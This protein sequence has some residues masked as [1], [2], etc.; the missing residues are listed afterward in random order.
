MR[1]IDGLVLLLVTVKS[2][3]DKILFGALI[4]QFASTVPEA[5]ASTCE[6][7]SSEEPGKCAQSKCD[8]VIGGSQY[9]SQ[10]SKAGEAPV[11]GVCT[12]EL[13]GNNC[14]TKI[15]TQ[16]AQGYFLHKGGCYKIGG[17]VGSLICADTS[18]PGVR[19]TAGVCEDCKSGYFKN[20]EAAAN[21]DSCISCGDQAGFTITGG[22]GNTYKG[23]QNCATC[24]PPERA[25]PGSSQQKEAMCESCV[26]GFFGSNNC[27]QQ[28]TDP[29]AACKTT[30]T[31]CTKCKPGPSNTKEYFKVTNLVEKTG[32]C[33]AQDACTDTYFPTTDKAGTKVCVTC[34][35]ETNGG[36][37]DCKTCISKDSVGIVKELTLTCSTCKTD[38]NKPNVVGSQCFVCPNNDSTKDCGKCSAD[39]LCEE[40]SGGKVLTPTKLCLEDCSGLPGYF[41]DTEAKQ[42]VSC[43]KDCKECTGKATQ[44]TACSP[45]RMLV[46]DK[47]GAYPYGT[48]VDQCVVAEGTVPGT[49]GTCGAKIGGTAYCSKCNVAA[50][51]PVNGVC[52][53]NNARNAPCAEADN[54]GGCNRCADGYFLFERGCY[55]TDKQPGMQVCSDATGSNGLCKTC[56]NGLPADNGNCFAQKC[57]P[58]C[59]TCSTAGDASKCKVCADGYYRETAGGTDGECK[60]CSQG[61]P[62]CTL[63][64]H[65]DAGFTCLST[66]PFNGDGD[67]TKPVDPP[68]SNESSLSTGAIAGI[69]VAVIVVVGGL[70]SFLCWWF[71]C[72]GKA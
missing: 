34:N 63:C 60:P 15:C 17:E 37:K 22:S 71:I 31:A 4:L 50:E 30:A 27:N 8:V 35:D 49:C 41:M 42:C 57:H 70:V 47:E 54:A 25:N 20:P 39:N 24:Q 7:S 9:C 53:T 26:D 56:A 48:C 10:C 32:E 33:I 19:A 11:N 62:G 38:T 66:D 52:E 65:S 46:Y 51:V 67:D 12:A 64:K 16:C 58:S 2:M 1:R 55:K 43:S 28:C 59:K 72:R 18:S 6:Q 29:C 23:V 5:K 45:G 3:F 68:S 44:C 61:K 36:I 21:A 40:C 69:S 14:A 13:D